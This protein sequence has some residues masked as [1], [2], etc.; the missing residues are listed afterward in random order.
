MKILLF[1]NTNLIFLH[2]DKVRVTRFLASRV[3]GTVNLVPI[4]RERDRTRTCFEPI[5]CTLGIGWGEDI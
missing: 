1:G 5:V 4:E 2:S 3:R